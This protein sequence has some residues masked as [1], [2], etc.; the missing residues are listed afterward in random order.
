MQR[1]MK[2]IIDGGLG[3]AAGTAAM[4]AAMLAARRTGLM[5]R[6][7]PVIIAE[8]ALDAS[9]VE[10]E[11]PE[12]RNLLATLLHF[13][14]GVGAGAVFGLVHNRLRL[15][16]WDSLQGLIFG[17]LVWLISYKGWVP[18]LGLMPPPERDQPGRPTTM[19]LSHF[20]YGAILGLIVG[21]RR[22][23]SCQ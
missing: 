23:V 16:V 22:V 21:R 15:P 20:V 12:A 17:S 18:A 19:L 9:G 3:G 11:P 7:P 10:G 13:G 14:F 8:G 2:A 6:L 5:A 4:S 1:D